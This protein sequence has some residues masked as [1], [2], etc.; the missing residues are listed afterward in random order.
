MVDDVLD[1]FLLGGVEAA[2]VDVD[3]GEGLVDLGLVGAE[4]VVCKIAQVDG[5]RAVLGELMGGG[6]ADA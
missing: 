1:G 6:T 2:N 4:M 3:F 5:S